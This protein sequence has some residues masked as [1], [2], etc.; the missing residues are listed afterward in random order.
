MCS[1]PG[2]RLLTVAHTPWEASPLPLTPLT[3]WDLGP[4][5][6]PDQPPSPV[7]HRIPGTSA[8][9]FP[10]L[11]PVALAEPGCPF[12]E[13]LELHD[14]LPAKLALEEEPQPG[15]P[16]QGGQGCWRHCPAL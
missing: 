2:P 4:L 11:G 10:S 7:L 8:Y 6:T 5:G 14:P 3:L 15:G 16:Q 1:H 13:V 12:G 9:A